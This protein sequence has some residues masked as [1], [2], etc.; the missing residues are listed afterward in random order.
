MIKDFENC[1]EFKK[2]TVKINSISCET[3]NDCVFV[4]TLLTD[5]CEVIFSFLFNSSKSLY[6]IDVGTQFHMLNNIENIFYL[7][8]FDGTVEEFY[9]TNERYYQFDIYFFEI[10]DIF[11]NFAIKH[12]IPKYFEKYFQQSKNCCALDIVLLDNTTTNIS[13]PYA[14]LVVLLDNT[15]TNISYP[16]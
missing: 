7:Q 9:F 2:S 4:K 15:T 10:E 8:L 16:Y 1:F 6:C 3:N 13:Y 12:I 14:S 11:L 5:N